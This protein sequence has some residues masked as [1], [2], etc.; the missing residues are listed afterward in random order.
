MIISFKK[1]KNEVINKKAEESYE[2]AKIWY[3]CP[4]KKLKMNMLKIENLVKLE[5]IVTLQ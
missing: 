4:Q 3:I 1:K 5:I 2:N